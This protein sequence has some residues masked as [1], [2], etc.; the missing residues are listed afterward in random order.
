MC[1]ALWASG[2]WLRYA[3]LEKKFCHLATLYSGNITVCK[4]D[5]GGPSGGSGPGVQYVNTL[6]GHTGSIQGGEIR[7]P[8]RELLLR[9]R[10]N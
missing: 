5:D 7:I 1:L 3:T 4:L 2:L 8:Q 10:M 9:Y 6:K